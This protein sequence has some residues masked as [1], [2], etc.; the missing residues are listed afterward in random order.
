MHTNAVQQLNIQT[1]THPVY[2]TPFNQSQRSH[3][4]RYSYLSTTWRS[5]YQTKIT[6][7]IFHF[8][9]TLCN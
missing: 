8:C 6:Y 4:V 1:C 3:H 5:T 7:Q 9:H 2:E